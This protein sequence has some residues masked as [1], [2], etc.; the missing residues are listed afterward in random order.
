MHLMGAQQKHLKRLC[1]SNQGVSKS[2]FLVGVWPSARDKKI[3][4]ILENGRA[5]ITSF[6]FEMGFFTSSQPTS[7]VRAVLCEA[8]QGKARYRVTKVT[9]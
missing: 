9:R 3:F 4:Y 2:I 7:C 6:F 5:L 8:R 1:F